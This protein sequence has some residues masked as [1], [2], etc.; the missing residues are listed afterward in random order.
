M[1]TTN[2]IDILVAIFLPPIGVFLK[3]GCHVRVYI[4]FFVCVCVFDDWPVTVHHRWSSGSV[5]FW[6]YL[7]IYQ[8][9]S[10]LSML[11]PNK[12]LNQT[13]LG[14]YFCESRLIFLVGTWNWRII[15]Y[16]GLFLQELKLG[17]IY[18]SIYRVPVV[19]F[20]FWFHCCCNVDL[21]EM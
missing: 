8:G 21:L 12:I 10:M 17:K 2:C 14:S 15:D 19:G 4:F 18:I 7:G 9:S 13:N 5:C 16:L 20:I 3:F 1:G 6:R 11:S